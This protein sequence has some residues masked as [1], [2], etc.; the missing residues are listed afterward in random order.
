MTANTQT[1]VTVAK[2]AH[3]QNFQNIASA[4]H[5]RGFN[6]LSTT[7]M[8]CRSGILKIV[9]QGIFRC[10]SISLFQVVTRAS[11]TRFSSYLSRFVLLL[12]FVDSADKDVRE[13]PLAYI[14]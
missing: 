5:Q 12:L 1:K 3:G 8:Y 10:A 6:P 14:F 7:L 2:N 11:V 9:A 13:S 4:I